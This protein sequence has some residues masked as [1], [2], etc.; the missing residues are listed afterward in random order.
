MHIALSGKTA[1]VTGSTA[2]IGYAVAKGLAECGAS[3]V[4]N[5]RTQARV[6]TA[7][8]KLAGEVRGWWRPALDR[9]AGGRARSGRKDRQESELESWT[10]ARNAVSRTP[11]FRRAARGAG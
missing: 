11:D 3:A 5:G 2:G 4:V 8:A 9:L 1:L 6:D 10:T 7:V